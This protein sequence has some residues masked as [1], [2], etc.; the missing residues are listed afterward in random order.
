MSLSG[1]FAGMAWVRWREKTNSERLKIMTCA[2]QAKNT[3]FWLAARG[4]AHI[5]QQYAMGC[6]HT[7]RSRESHRRGQNKHSGRPRRQG[8]MSSHHISKPPR[9][10]EVLWL[11]RLVRIRAI[12][13]LCRQSVAVVVRDSIQRC[14]SRVS[15]PPLGFRGVESLSKSSIGDRHG[16]RLAAS[17]ANDRGRRVCVFPY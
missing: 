7:R 9:R 16:L 4:A 1:G 6:T 2:L 10:R 17:F 5:S 11:Q 8:R 3:T 14:K 13:S 15:T 12:R